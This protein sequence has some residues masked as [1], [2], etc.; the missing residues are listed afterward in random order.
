M[1]TSKSDEYDVVLLDPP[2]SGLSKEGLLELLRLR[3]RRIVYLSCDP[4][5]LARDV[6]GMRTDGYRVSR[7]QGFD[8]FPQ[9]MHVET[10]V[11]LTAA[12]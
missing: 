12:T 11:E 9:T 5:T 6:R 1:R 7:I 2:R 10:V 3:P 4:P 8:M